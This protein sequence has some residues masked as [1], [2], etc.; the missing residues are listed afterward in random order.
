[1]E[2]R[3][4][5]PR[6]VEQ[7]AMLKFALLGELPRGHRQLLT[8]RDAAG[9]LLDSRLLKAE[10]AA[11]VFPL[12]AAAG[13]PEP[14]P[15]RAFGGFLFLGVEHI[16]TGYDHL[17]FLAAL[18]LVCEGYGVAIKIITCFTI[19]HSLTLALATFGMVELSPRVV[20]PVIAAS[21]VFV[22][23]ENVLRG[24][25]QRW[26]WMLTLAFGLVHGLGF[27]GVLR[28]LDVGRGAPSE[29]VWPLLSFNLGVELGQLG[30]AALLL[31]LLLY[32]RSHP[33][34]LR[35][36]IPALSALIACAGGYWMMQRLI[37]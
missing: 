34:F 5:F 1:M 31:P 24:S 37:A 4:D 6:G 16:L 30:V 12:A 2:L 9:A 21:I 27:A 25:R 20:E 32:G 28:E 15:E 23:I 7:R 26:R 22:G 14:V 17:L 3:L 10:S 29:A 11:A 36:G 8:V 19:A 33:L 13:E 18:L 35:R